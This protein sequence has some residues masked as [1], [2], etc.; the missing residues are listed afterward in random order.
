MARSEPSQ[1][2]RAG[3]PGSPV[4]HEVAERI[5]E[6]EALDAPAEKIAGQV[7]RRLGRSRFGDL[8]AG[9]WLGHALH[10]FFT[11]LPIGSW[12]SATLLDLFG[13]PDSDAASD[14][15]V[16]FGIAAS[17]PTAVTGLTDWADT[18]RSDAHVRRIGLVH[19][20][21]NTAGLGLFA[22]SLAARRRGNRSRGKALGLAGM[23]ALTVGGHLG[24]HLSYSKGVGVDQT[25]F[26][27]G[28]S[29]WTVALADAAL[30]EGEAKA[31]DVEGVSVLVT[32]QDDRVF[33]LS[34]RCS[35]RGGPLERGEIANGC[36]TCPWHGSVFRLEDGSVQRGPSAYPQPVFDV[37]IRD[38]SIEVR[39]P[40]R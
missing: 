37:R 28:P 23:G 16:A 21:A 27:R 34:S 8:L 39:A 38:G 32:R 31:V 5:G 15:L 13:G 9:T 36:V 25:V 17:L 24:A 4:M 3:R 12:T 35:H 33:A 11:D 19:A 10:P 2:W 26:E 6:V 20:L 40:Q 29:E 22:A 30:G 18:T 7:S 1:E 14:R